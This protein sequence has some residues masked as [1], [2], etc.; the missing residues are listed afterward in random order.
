MCVD[1]EGAKCGS[2]GE[3]GWIGRRVLTCGGRAGRGLDIGIRE[4]RT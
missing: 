1:R 3:G 2:G 4:R